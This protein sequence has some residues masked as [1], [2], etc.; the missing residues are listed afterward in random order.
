MPIMREAACC[1]SVSPVAGLTFVYAFDRD[2]SRLVAHGYT[3]VMTTP[4][5]PGQFQVVG[6]DAAPGWAEWWYDLEVY[7]YPDR[8]LSELG[9]GGR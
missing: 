9:W 5:E 8:P 1:V 6:R 7:E 4:T 2:I 3:Q